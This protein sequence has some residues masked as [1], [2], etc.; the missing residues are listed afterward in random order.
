MTEPISAEGR[1][2]GKVAI[3]VGGGQTPGATTGNGRATALVFAREG[4]R[5]VVIDR[6]VDRAEETAA[7]ILA[8]GGTAT[9]IGADVTSSSDC[10]A[11]VAHTLAT[12]GRVDILHNNVGIGIGDASALR[13]TEEAWHRIIDTNLTSMLLTSRAVLPSMRDRRDGVIINVSSIASIAST[14]LIA[15]KVSK[16]GVNALTQQLAIANAKYGIRVNAILPGLMDTPMAVDAAATARGVDREEIAA[17][18][19]A[20]VPLRGRQGTAWDVAHAALFLGSDEA[21][22]ISGVLLPVDGAQ[23]LQVH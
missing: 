3:V 20:T 22:F 9:A 11:F 14:P 13:V 4:A 1:L 15:Y 16:A 8:A 18:R 19:A 7:E 6:K 23:S 10:E 5:V 12:Y 21:S 2:A 17:R